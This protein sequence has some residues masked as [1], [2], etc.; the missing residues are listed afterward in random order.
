MHEA[1]GS[2]L[3]TQNWMRDLT[4]ESAID[5]PF[6]NLAVNNNVVAVFAGHTHDPEWLGP[7]KTICN[8]RVPLINS[9]A[10]WSVGSSQCIFV[11]KLIIETNSL[12]LSTTFPHPS[13][14]ITHTCCCMQV[15]NVLGGSIRLLPIYSQ[16][17][18]CDW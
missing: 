8:G 9:G 6:C 4:K 7:S 12:I 11:C 14:H 17:Q 3:G 10:S 1:Q 16:S 18:A 13:K 5:G 2:D 15:P